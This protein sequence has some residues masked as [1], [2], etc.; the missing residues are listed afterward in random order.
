MNGVTF[1]TEAEWLATRKKYL[2][3]SDAAAVVGLSPYMTPLEL[4][5]RKRGELPEIT[6]SIPMMVG[7]ALEGVLQRLYEDKTGRVV[8]GS[9][10]FHVS[11]DH[12]FMAATIDGRTESTINGF[13]RLVE[14]KTANH[15]VAGQW[16]E[17][18]T[19]E[20]PGQYLI[21][22]QHQMIV[23]GAEVADIAVLIG[24]AD[25]RVYTVPRHESLCQA[26]VERE[27]AFWE[28]VQTG[29]TPPECPQ[30]LRLFSR[31]A[32][33]PDGVADLTDNPEVLADLAEYERSKLEESAAKDRADL[34]KYRLIR[35]MANRPE[36]I[37]PGGTRLTRKLV[38]ISAHAV[39]A[40]EYYRFGI[41]APKPQ[42]GEMND[43]E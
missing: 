26:I 28:C 13:G 4:Y 3:A 30:D 34:A 15:R 32:P 29:K 43:G 36:A 18:G 7:K 9:Q 39:K 2:G 22:V 17:P 24:N 6:E 5:Y 1:A 16:G 27:A 10:E 14:L 41:K 20:V 38:K 11:P 23:T 40:S 42:N 8:G 12:P 19:D 25:F 35:A 37:L 31:L 33:D 21:Q